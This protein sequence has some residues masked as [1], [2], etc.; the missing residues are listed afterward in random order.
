[1]LLCRVQ[2]T[3]VATRKHR[4]LEGWKLTVCQ[5]INSDGA[6]EGSP[7][8]AVDPLGA[9]RGQRVIIS[10]D[11][12][13]TRRLLGDDRSPARWVLIGIVDELDVRAHA[14]AD[15]RGDAA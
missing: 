6:P 2:G 7:Q 3:V 15:A 12:L 11:G 10:S 8:V 14:L 4:S 9:D 13:A 5:P 1:V